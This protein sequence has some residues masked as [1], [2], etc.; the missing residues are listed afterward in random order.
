MWALRAPGHCVS[1]VRVQRYTAIWSGSAF[2]WGWA[3]PASFSEFEKNFMESLILAQNER[4][5]RA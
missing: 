5:R 1:G 3:M 2:G 4:W